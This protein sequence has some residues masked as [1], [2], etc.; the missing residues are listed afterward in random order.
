VRGKWAA[1][2]PP[3]FFAWII[4]GRLAVSERPGGYARNHRPVRRREELLWLRG[5]GFVRVVSLLPSPHNLHAY[6]EAGLAWAHIP[7]APQ[8]DAASVL[9]D[10]YGRIH[11][12]LADGEQLLVHQEELG[13]RLMGVVAGY[14]LWS[15]LVQSGPQAAA[16]VERILARQMGPVGRQLIATVPALPPPPPAPPS[17]AADPPG[18]ADPRGIGGG[19]RAEPLGS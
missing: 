10:L 7:F 3:R 6:D 9:S 18:V 1:G 16:V 8:D 13:D 2:I 17:G 14:L 19:R 11:G 12:W 5:Q 15:G 4:K